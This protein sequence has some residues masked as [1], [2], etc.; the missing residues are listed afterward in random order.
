ML[1]LFQHPVTHGSRNLPVGRQVNSGRLIYILT[2]AVFSFTL[3]LMNILKEVKTNGK[4]IT[5]VLAGMLFSNLITYSFA[6]GGDTNLIHS[7]IS[8][9]G[10]IRIVGA[11]DTCKKMNQHW[12]GIKKVFKDHRDSQVIF[13]S[14]V[15]TVSLMVLAHQMKY[16]EVD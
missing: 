4:V 5:L 3:N 10:G 9:E 14:F 12:I 15:L 2:L 1:N 8:K 7:C 11:N 16:S 13:P 6:H